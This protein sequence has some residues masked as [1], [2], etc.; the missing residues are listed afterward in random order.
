MPNDPQLIGL[1]EV[2]KAAA[3]AETEF[4][5]I[6][7]R[8]AEA[9]SLLELSIRQD[10]AAKIEAARSQTAQLTEERKVA[11]ANRDALRAQVNGAR[12]ALLHP[13][14]TSLALESD[15]PIVFLPI[16]LETKF[17]LTPQGRN[18]LI[19]IYPD[20]LHIDT[21]EPGLT[22]A[23][24]E[25]GRRFQEQSSGGEENARAAWNQ[26][27]SRVGA[28]RAAWIAKK[29]E[30]SPDPFRREA[31][32][33]R[34]PRTALLPD[35]WHAVAVVPGGPPK[36]ETGALIPDVLPVGPEPLVDEERPQSP[37]SQDPMTLIGEEM[38]WLI[39][40]KEALKVGMAIRLRDV[41]P[42]VHRLIVYGVKSTM[43]A[44]ESAEKLEAM[45]D[46]HHYTGSLSFL[47]RG[48]PTNNTA[49]VLSGYDSK[50]LGS[51]RSFAAERGDDLFTPGDKSSGDNATFAFGVNP[52]VFAHVRRADGREE[53]A[54]RSM[55]TALWAATWGYFIDH[56]LGPV[57]HLLEPF[58]ARNQLTDLRSHFVK[59]VRGGGPL[60]AVRIGK[61]PYGL[62]PV[63]SRKH[64]QPADADDVSHNIFTDVIEK[65][66][67]SFRNALDGGLVPKV[68]SSDPEQSLLTVLQQTANSSSYSVRHVL[69]PLFLHHYEFF[70]GSLLKQDWWT[71][72][73]Q[74][75]VPKIKLPQMGEGRK[76]STQSASVESRTAKPFE[77]ALIQFP[78]LPANDPLNPNYI[79]SL[80]TTNLAALKED[81]ILPPE[82]FPSGRPLLYRLLRHSLMCEY[83]NAADRIQESAFIFFRRDVPEVELIGMT[84]LFAPITFWMQM[85]E[86]VPG[87]PAG[88]KL[89]PFL[90]DAANESNPHVAQ[91]AETRAA[92]RKLAELTTHE[93]Q[94]LLPETLEL[95]LRETL[96]TCSHRFD[97]WMTSFATRRLEWIRTNRKARGVYIGGYGWVEHLVQSSG[98]TSEGFIHGPSIAHATT[99]A[100]L[101]NGYLTHRKGNE[102]EREPF[103]IDM[104]SDRV[105]VARQL[106]RGVRQGQPLA[107]L[108]GY[109]IERALQEKGK[110]TFI[111]RFRRI[112]LLEGDA[113]TP[114]TP[115][116]SVAAN[117]VVNGIL[118]LEKRKTNHP[119][120]AGLWAS[121]LIE[122]RR[123]VEA[124]LDDVANA[125]DALGDV[126]M[127]EKVFQATRGNFDR[128]GYTVD[129]IANG[130]PMS[131]PDV[132]DT[133]RTG[134]AVSH[135]VLFFFDNKPEQLA[136]WSSSIRAAAEPRLNALASQLLPTPNKVWC[137]AQYLDP[138]TGEPLPVD[139]QGNLFRK[140]ELSTLELSPLDAIYISSSRNSGERGELEQRLELLL[141][142][143]RPAHIAADVRVR[144]DY[145]HDPDWPEDV[146]SFSQFQLIVAGVRGFLTRARA[147]TPGDLPQQP[148]PATLALDEF[149]GRARAVSDALR[150]HRD[151]LN[152]VVDNEETVAL[153]DF[154]NVLVQSAFLGIKTA[155]PLTATNDLEEQRA[156]L[157][158]QT[159]SV[160]SDVQALI[161]KLD[162]VEA[163]SASQPDQDLRRI[164][165]VLGS[166]FLA[167]P[168]LLPTDVSE[169]KAAFN[170]SGKLQG[171][172]PRAAEGWLLR[173]ARVREPL[174]ALTDAL[175]NSDV[176]MNHSVPVSVAQLPYVPDD[177]WIAHQSVDGRPLPEGRTSIVA[178]GSVNLTKDTPVDAIVID[179]W[180]EMVPNAR[181]TTGV[182]F[183]FD[184]PGARPPQAVLLA[185][186]P[187][188][189][190]PWNDETIQ[191][192]LME[193]IEL[194]H[195]RA[196][197]QT[198]MVELDH[199]LP[200]LYFALNAAGDT[201]TTNFGAA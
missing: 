70:V 115:I 68:K 98:R 26:L 67:D 151:A 59:Y 60:P 165:A 155:V 199:Y 48:V 188:L 24:F 80:V 124:V 23:E 52:K 109:R 161:K 140:V 148:S 83:A 77:S 194:S 166:D 65:F 108:L 87:M 160:L 157:S 43:H 89:G 132:L 17:E 81:R 106:I 45:F 96:D 122:E 40:F 28:P 107:A 21:H 64:W 125:R 85:E 175:R 54:A 171:D 141:R 84:D 19:R 179:E 30:E 146:F 119:D 38:R 201:I 200:A 169:L 150:A 79:K 86:P 184:Q 31:A 51:E 117:N 134:T 9:R 88:T 37:E 32:W 142:N 130:K 112:A 174:H 58:L 57:E 121:V 123:I 97:A 93:S 69:G 63:T 15:T 116:E 180:T 126:L 6:S 29:F 95:L 162:E 102:A 41:P 4:N 182:A 118:L 143:T 50:D 91:L 172:N 170:A 5:N 135:K 185:V 18:L 56:R 152:E 11:R 13:Q 99:G 198:A 153:K 7:V 197:D 137:R 191:T 129:D 92:L 145:T 101:A 33:T 173:A 158:A 61:Q 156:L 16:R 47:G 131:E 100:L 62:L 27:V 110:Q 190:A 74:L 2:R 147:L 111:A 120:Y 1:A 82:L 103:V 39:D 72:Q 181:E 193:T 94:P 8:L 42:V 163:Q 3:L 34:A 55:N 138:Q 46:A 53:I 71:A 105:R 75:A 10:D 167:V 159:R 187:D 36:R 186:A 183:H 44:D 14:E 76:I 113:P 196:V 128:A 154:Q 144:L 90:D 12:A 189:A 78:P 168:H 35:R 104:S 127:A 192:T 22:N 177:H 66:W 164:R 49:E 73:Q 25:A 195:M 133:P 20:D 178:C 149:S 176:L 136:L 139:D 114:S